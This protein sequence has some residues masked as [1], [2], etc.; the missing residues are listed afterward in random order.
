MTARAITAGELAKLRSENQFSELF[1]AIH[2]PAVIYSARV[3]QPIFENPT[4]QITYDGGSGTLASVKSGMTLYV[5]SS[6]GAYDKGMVRIRKTPSSTIFYIGETAEIDFE[7]G[8]YLTVVNEF[9]IWS[10]HVAISGTTP[11]MDTDVLYSDQHTDLDPVPILGPPAVLWLTGATVNFSPSASSSWVLGSTI[12]SYLWVAT[13]ASATANLDT[14]TPTITYNAV[15]QYRVDC[16]VTAANGKTTTGYRMVFVYSSASMPITQFELQ[17]CSGE[18]ESGGWQFSVKLYD[19]VAIADVREKAMVVLFAR[20][21]YAG[22]QESLGA[23]TG[24]ENVVTVG[25]IKQ[26]DFEVSSEFS[27][28][29]FTVYGPQQWLKEISGYPVGMEYVDENASAWTQMDDLTVDH[30]L[31]HLLH[32]RS[33]ATLCMDI[34]LSGESS[35]ASAMEA[36]TGSLWDQL[37]TMSKEAILAT[38]ACNRYGQLYVQV[39]VPYMEEA[40]RASVPTVMEVLFSDWQDTLN[41]ERAPIPRVAMVEASGISYDGSTASP[42]FSRAPGDVL[43]RYGNFISKDRLLLYDQDFCND[44]C[45]D[46]YAH[47][48]N[49]YPNIDFS[50]ASNNRFIDIV[51]RQRLT[52][53]IGELNIPRG[54]VWTNKKLLP[55]RVSYAHDTKS[56]ILTIS[57]ET[58]SETSGEA[59]GVVGVTVIVPPEAIEGETPIELPEFEDVGWAALTPIGTFFPPYIPVE[60]P[61]IPG[62]DCPADAPANGPY[63][64]SIYGELASHTTWYKD[65]IFNVVVRTSGH[66]HKTTYVIKGTFQKLR[67]GE[68]P[69][70]PASYEETLDDNWYDIFA[71]DYNHNLIAT[72]VHD[73]VTNPKVRTGVL[74]APAATQINRI[75]LSMGSNQL[76]R[77]TKIEY[78]DGV[79]QATGNEKLSGDSYT[80][81]IWGSGIW[82]RAQN[83]KYAGPYGDGAAGVRYPGVW[84]YINLGENHEYGGK[85]FYIKQ[86]SWFRLSTNTGVGL[87]Y[88]GS[89]EG[90]YAKPYDFSA[91]WS[92]GVNKHDPTGVVISQEH[93]G[94]VSIAEFGDLYFS[95]NS[96]VTVAGVPNGTYLS[97]C[98]LHQIY[99][100]PA[101]TYRVLISQVNIWNVCPRV[102]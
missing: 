41:I 44:L 79:W 38:P 101:S 39:D 84:Q 50:L 16:T 31:W 71:Y 87:G 102:S 94:I 58:K 75:E 26:E 54:I 24:Y 28:V 3:N 63:S 88:M 100:K 98:I 81:G 77:P 25:W 56:G 99:V 49:E 67:P 97:E 27:T 61:V 17:N 95:T 62:T 32:W 2:K 13:G 83:I 36:P 8:D 21:H 59:I 46:I 33:T 68:D 11:L 23:T 82:V 55:I 74:N 96:N 66:D 15:G 12:S 42:L 91:S 51:P 43:S 5:G 22:T 70:N 6:A 73:P 52:I 47:E 69:E 40:D 29:T 72:G 1:L 4:A 14:A 92:E 7:D 89:I 45:A 85:S 80:S 78:S 48:N 30:A 19:Q 34:T 53:S 64:L 93:V 90:R 18:L 9:G 76:F 86:F 37:V 57:I 20:D 65:A 10:R 60:P 35:L